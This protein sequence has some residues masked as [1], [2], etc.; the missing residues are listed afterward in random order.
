MSQYDNLTVSVDSSF[1]FNVTFFWFSVFLCLNK[2]IIFGFGRLFREE[3]LFGDMKLR[4]GN[5]RLVFSK[6]TVKK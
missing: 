3:N 5:L 2:L 6:L 4:S 1:F